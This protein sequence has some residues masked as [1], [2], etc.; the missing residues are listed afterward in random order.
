MKASTTLA[1]GLPMLSTCALAADLSVKIEIPQM[2]VAE[3]HRPYIAMW[4]EKGDQ[5]VVTPLA[6]LYD[7]KKRDNGGTKW[8]KDMR[9]FWRKVGR[10]LSYPVD[11]VSGATKTTGEHTI[12]F[13]AKKAELDKLPAGDYTLAVEVA[14]EA[15][16]RELVRIPFRLPVT[17]KQTFSAKGKEEVGNISLQVAP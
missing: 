11:G 13:P 2:N 17:G 15:G 14:R 16:G 9:T 4:L 12:S 10:D 5:S 7:I 8:L 3:Y 6:V 1:F